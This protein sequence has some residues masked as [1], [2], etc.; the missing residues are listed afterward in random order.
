MNHIIDSLLERLEID[1]LKKSTDEQTCPNGSVRRVRCLLSG[2]GSERLADELTNRLAPIAPKIFI[3]PLPNQI[4]PSGNEQLNANEILLEGDFKEKLSAFPSN[5][6]DLIVSF[7]TIS[8]NE[9]KKTIE[10]ICQK[11]KKGG[12]FGLIISLDGSPKIP[13]QIINRILKE[14]SVGLKLY[15]SAL[16]D[17]ISA[18]RKLVEK[19]GFFNN[20]VWPMTITQRYPDANA[21]FDALITQSAQG[22]FDRK[23]NISDQAYI[24]KRFGELV[25][26]YCSPKEPKPIEVQ[27]ELGAAVGIK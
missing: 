17:S 2:V 5:T 6:L 12:Q 18:L 24:R 9:P 11:L 27:F 19:S 8:I 16:P 7:W 4:T 15:R 3:N 22:L 21:V 20:R 13:F 25:A 14:K 26:E 10:N 1:E 23:V